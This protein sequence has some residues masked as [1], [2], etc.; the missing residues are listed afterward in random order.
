M[1][2]AENGYLLT[3]GLTNN[4]WDNQ[5]TQNNKHIE[6]SKDLVLN[7]GFKES[8]ERGL[9]TIFLPWTVVFI[10]PYLLIGMAP[11][12]C[13]L[14]TSAIT[15]FCFIRYGWKHWIKHIETPINFDF[16]P[17]LADPV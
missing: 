8:V 17:E 1:D 10:N 2:K 5:T 12:M 15:H 4:H 13:Y 14:L 6:N 9:I 7:V 11:V 16:A 3:S